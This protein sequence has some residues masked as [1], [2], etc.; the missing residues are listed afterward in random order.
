MHA[1]INFYFL[2]NLNSES[3]DE[4]MT[5]VFSVNYVKFDESNWKLSICSCAWWA[6][7]FKCHHVIEMAVRK[8]LAEYPETAQI[9][10]L[11][12]KRK[13]GRPQNNTPALIKQPSEAYNKQSQSSKRY[14]ANHDLSSESSD[15]SICSP[16]QTKIQKLNETLYCQNCGS[17]MKKKWLLLPPKMWEKK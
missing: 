10:P 3:F 6:K 16:K 12:Q 5:K 7:H 11:G 17:E 9:I 13:R 4:L 8:G 14:T 1:K 15:S 2:E